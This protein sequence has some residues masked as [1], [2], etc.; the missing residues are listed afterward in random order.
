M[1]SV[2]PKQKVFITH[3]CA[4]SFQDFSAILSKK[5]SKNVIQIFTLLLEIKFLEIE[6]YLSE[7]MGNNL[8]CQI[9][10][11]I[12]LDLTYLIRR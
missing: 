4:N 8:W 5:L 6:C 9:E 1:L 11:C 2:G 3:Q 12:S 7:K 10:M